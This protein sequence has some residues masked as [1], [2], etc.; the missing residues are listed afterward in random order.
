MV[1]EIARD[2]SRRVTLMHKIET[3]NIVGMKAHMEALNYLLDLESNEVLMVG[4]WGMGGIGK[5]SIAKCLYDQLSPKFRARCFTDNIKSVS[6][7]HDHDLKHLQKELLCSILCDDIRLWS[8]EAGC[9]EIKK[10][11][12]NQKVFL[13][14][15]GV[16]KVAQVHALA[17]ERN[18]FG[19]GSRIIMT[20]RDMGLLNTC[21]IEIIYEVKCLDDKDAL[22]M[23][24][25][26]AFEGGRPPDGF[27]Q[28]SIRASRLAHGLPSAIQAYALF[29]CGR[30]A[31][32]EEWE[33]ALAA[34]ENSLDENIMEI[35]KISY[36]GLPKPHQNVFLHVACL[37]NGDTLQ[38]ITSL[39]HGPI[40]QSSLWIRVLA[41]K[42]LIK[43]STNGSVIMHKLVEQ[44]G[45]DIIRD[46]RSLAQKFLRNPLEI[47]ALA[48]RDVSI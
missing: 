16:D 36:E 15:D 34:L 22:Q 20:T 28:L 38:R 2:I 26:I 39:L 1:G 43:I 17:K 12:G 10:R 8:V 19:P 11:L 6:K 41:E 44:M 5:T 21:G 45:R 46:D 37:F 4:I 9:Q 42:S 7:D 31:R 24:K 30:T 27:E 13:V 32:P 18:W 23:F 47:H 3:G 14:L 35:L 25:Q 40:P 48:F 33:E 29:L